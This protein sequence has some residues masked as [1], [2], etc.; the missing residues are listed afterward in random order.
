M[1]VIDANEGRFPSEQIGN[2]YGVHQGTV[3]LTRQEVYE[4]I[5]RFALDKK[6]G[7][8]T[9]RTA[10]FSLSVHPEVLAAHV[11]LGSGVRAELYE[12]Y[13]EGVLHL[14]PATARR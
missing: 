10:D 4:A 13:L 8:G 12:G 2:Q 9:P 7:G 3:E 1:R 6:L 5:A 11:V 14:L